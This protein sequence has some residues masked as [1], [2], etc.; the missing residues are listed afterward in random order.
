MKKE[1]KILIV[2]AGLSGIC[3]G[4]HSINKGHQVTLLDNL[5]NKSSIIAAGQ[6]NPMV[7]RRMTKSWRLDDFLP[8]AE[9]FYNDLTTKTGISIYH[10]ITIRR[11][12][13]S[14][15]EKVM[16][17]EKQNTERFEK[18]LEPI[19][20]EDDHY[21][22]AQNDFGSGRIKGS[23][24]V[25]TTPFLTAGKKWIKEN[26]KLIEEHANYSDFNPELGTFKGELFDE[27]IFCEG[28]SNNLNPWFGYLP[29][30][31][32]KGE[33]LTIQSNEIN[34]N[35]SLNRKCF[36]LPIGNKQF[37]LGA[38]YDWHTN[39]TDL[40]EE[41]KADL[42]DKAQLL[43]KSSFEIIEH[44]AGI[45]PTSPDR[46]PIIGRHHEYSK[47]SIFNGL[48]TKG[49]LIAPKLSEEFVQFLDEE[50]ELDKEVRMER[51]LKFLIQ[52]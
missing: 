44:K 21:S 13:S 16:W 36:L 41:G 14:E 2:G 47:L 45:R 29:V 39:N 8:F 46:R 48:G 25:D 9:N 11:M 17:I 32:T 10:P 7:F 35:E 5:V 1:K 33:V 20:E 49:Y 18:Y 51:Y 24:Y 23:S 37:R 52:N 4:I 6:I 40:T 15:H 30:E 38:T 12:F 26:G 27:I 22:S 42:L 50:A 3:V 28:S 19:T 43:T 31:H 34:E